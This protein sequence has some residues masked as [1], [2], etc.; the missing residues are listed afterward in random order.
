MHL[1]KKLKSPRY[2]QKVS[3]RWKTSIVW[4]LMLGLHSLGMLLLGQPDIKL[5][6]TELDFSTHSPSGEQGCG[7][8]CRNSSLHGQRSRSSQPY[9]DHRIG[10]GRGERRRVQAM[11]NAWPWPGFQKSGLSWETARCFSFWFM[12]PNSFTVF[13]PL[14]DG[15]RRENMFLNIACNFS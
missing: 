13:I 15:C 14:D 1:E 8:Q 11:E 4:H 2:R 10:W 9:W 7:L 5:L 12:F 3:T 6:Q